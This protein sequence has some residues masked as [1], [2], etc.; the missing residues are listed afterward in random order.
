MSR[1]L[2]HLSFLVLGSLLFTMF[3]VAPA[4]DTKTLIRQ[5]KAAIRAAENSNDAQVKNAKLD[6]ARKLI[7]QIK[8]TDPQNSELRSLESKYR[9]MDT[10]REATK[11][12]TS[13]PAIDTGKLK[14]VLADWNTIIGLEKEL[15]DK[16]NRFFPH[17]EGLS[18]TKEQTDQVLSIR[19]DVLK[20]DRPR[21]MAYLK[22]F[23]AKYG[24]P[25]D[26]MDRKISDLTPRNPKKGMYDEE[27]QRPS[28]PPS[29][30]YKNILE[31][32][33]WVQETPKTEAKL[34]MKRALE[35]VSNADF[36]MD[37]KR[38]AQFAEAEAELLRAKRFNPE[39]AEIAQALATVK[40]N[41]K[42]S[43]AD[44]QKAL[45]SARFP[46]TVSSFAGPGKPAELIAAVKSYFAETY[47]KEKVL[48]A[49]ISGS[50]VATKHNILG[51]P[52]QWGLPVYC[53]SQQ[54][55]PGIC[56]VFKMTVLTGIGVNTAKAP[57]FT[58]HWT[59]D[60]YRMKIA[61]L[62]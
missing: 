25:T 32:L 51:Q 53:A 29:R 52:T 6:E 11:A 60:S 13:T 50:W 28:Q 7:D 58:D 44:V 45:E 43:Q 2:H 39:D 61:N 1:F 49:S 24:E 42:K 20:N 57:P 30:A 19:D 62:K 33:A 36:F 46:A 40:A 15:H 4:E 14:E 59:G 10:G 56:R 47:P 34:I 41:R 31:R 22:E 55:E 48:A 23:S 37:T 54:N 16:T 12:S 3:S 17:A 18:Y 38:E 8:V 27:N 21:M 9:Y 35:M 26:D 5:A